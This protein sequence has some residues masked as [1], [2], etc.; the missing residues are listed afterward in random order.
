[1]SFEIIRATSGEI[2]AK[3]LKPG[4]FAEI[5]RY[6]NEYQPLHKQHVGAIVLRVINSLV[7]LPMD[8]CQIADRLEDACSRDGWFVRV[9]PNGMQFELR[10]NE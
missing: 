8:P 9:L 5:V 4:Q 2:P 7:I 3:L 10:N 6:A 1:M